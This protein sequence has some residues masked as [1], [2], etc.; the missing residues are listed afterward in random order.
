V[1][2]SFWHSFPGEEFWSSAD[3]PNVD[4][5]D[6][7]AYISTG[8]L[9]DPVHEGD[10]AAYHADYSRRVRENLNYYAGDRPTKP[11][12]RGEAGIDFVDQQK[13]QPDLALDGDGVWLHNFVW[14]GLDAG[15]LMEL[16][17]WN[18]NL[19]TQPG[20]DGQPGLHEIY[21]T[22]YRFISSIPLNNGH[23]QDAEPIVSSADLRAWGQKDLVNGHAHLWLQNRRHTW[24]AVVDGVV[25]APASGSITLAGFTPGQVYQVEW[26]DTWIP[27]PAAQTVTYTQIKANA[28]GEIM[29]QALTVPKDLALKIYPRR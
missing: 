17:W 11:I 5:A 18:D 27:D 25:I 3:Y 14:A 2:T 21:G 15:G 20:P 24:R 12:V 22:F 7:H 13:E 10:A 4:Y 9:D 6:V 23:Y 29:L 1:T 16:Y 19:E 28:G 26:W 8:W